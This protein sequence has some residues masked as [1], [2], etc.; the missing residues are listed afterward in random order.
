V[1]FVI[2]SFSRRSDQVARKTNPV[3]RCPHV[4]GV[5]SKL[6]RHRSEHRFWRTAS[7]AIGRVQDF[8]RFVP[9]RP[10]G[11][12]PP[13]TVP[14]LGRAGV[15]CGHSIEQPRLPTFSRAA[16]RSRPTCAAPSPSMAMAGPRVTRSRTSPGSLNKHSNT[17]RHRRV[18]LTERNGG[19]RSVP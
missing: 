9:W 10:R 6:N 16:I 15:A 8:P 12:R 2:L 14:A 3:R 5:A 11:G 17:S 4:S 13:A 7:G 1:V 19:W 18:G